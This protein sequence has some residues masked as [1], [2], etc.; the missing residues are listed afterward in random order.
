[1]RRIAPAQGGIMR[2]LLEGLYRFAD[3]AAGLPD[4][5]RA[6]TAMP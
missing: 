6:P 2:K 3:Y 5:G 1:L 4:L